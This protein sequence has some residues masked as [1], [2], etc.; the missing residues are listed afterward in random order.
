MDKRGETGEAAAVS[1]DAV[2]EL[3]GVERHR[4]GNVRRAADL[5]VAV[6]VAI[7]HLQIQVRVAVQYSQDVIQVVA[8]NTD[9]RAIAASVLQGVD[10]Q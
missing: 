6:Q 8:V 1:N 4:D 9:K 7:H 10:N 2:A 3:P 5:A